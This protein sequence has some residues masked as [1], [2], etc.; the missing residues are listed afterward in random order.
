MH[1][2]P[3]SVLVAA[4]RGKAPKAQN[5]RPRLTTP[6]ANALAGANPPVFKA[7]VVSEDEFHS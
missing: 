5:G 6:G 1:A 7:T 3:I 4:L 2:A